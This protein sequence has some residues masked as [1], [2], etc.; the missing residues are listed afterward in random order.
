MNARVSDYPAVVY[1]AQ[2][3]PCLSLYQG[4]HRH[5]PENQQ[6]P[7]RFR[8][9][10]KNME[11]SLKKKY[12]MRDVAPLMQPL[13]ELAEDHQFWN[14]TLDGLAIFSGHDFFKVHRLQ[15]PV[16][17][18][19]VVADSFHTKPLLRIY[20][21]YE[22]YQVLALTRGEVRMYEG[23]KD[24]LDELSLPEGF[25]R[26]LTEALGEE[27]TAPHQTVASYGKGVRGPA[28][29]YGHG[30]KKDEAEID[31]ERFFR[32][33]D[34][35]VVEHFSQT[36]GLPLLLAALPEN[37][38]MFRQIAQNK[39][40]LD[41]GIE[42]NPDALKKGSLHQRSWAVFEP[43]ISS[44]I[45]A[46]IGEYEEASSK[47]L[48]SGD[49]EQVAAAAVQGKVATLLIDNDVQVP[50]RL[51]VS[52]GDIVFDELIDPEVDDLLDD[53]GELVLQKGG[54]VRVIPSSMMPS[55]TGIAGV[56]RF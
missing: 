27:I 14:H 29:H 15:E 38:G 9:L 43:Q 52:T 22:R 47:G 34:K 48:G 8:N 46:L 33:V 49:L 50:G 31:A 18:I 30:S 10:L 16:K 40:L 12:P 44:R 20:Q 45:D 28:M 53:L 21:T 24:S 23:T 6:D 1:A 35:A 51:D 32:V 5:H 19:V 54:M 56:F 3:P 39:Y 37:Q 25:P 26:T 41:Q 11:S 7:I 2:E 36:S 17:D 42:I 55:P 4:T 13:Y